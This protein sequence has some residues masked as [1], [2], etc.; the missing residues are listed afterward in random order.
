MTW[1]P[2]LPGVWL[3]R[4]SCNVYAVQGPDGMLIVNAG[5]GAWLDHLDELPARPVALVCTHY[6]RDHAAGASPGDDNVELPH[7][8]ILRWFR[9]EVHAPSA[10]PVLGIASGT[11]RA[12]DLNRRHPQFDRIPWVT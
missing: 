6:F 5:T 11:R 2:I 9:I 10:D 3:F 7:R 1:Q 8:Q 12:S 4:D